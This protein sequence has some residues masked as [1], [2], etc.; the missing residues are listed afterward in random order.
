MAFR[1]GTKYPTLPLVLPTIYG[2]IEGMAP[3]APLE[4]SFPG[5]VSYTLEPADMHAG[6]LKARTEMHSDWVS[7]WI[8][9]LD[10]E[11]KR[12]Y[13]L[14]TLLHP[15][16]KTYH[17][18]EDFRLL[19]ESEKAWALRELRSEWATT[20]K[21]S[22]STQVHNEGAD[23]DSS[24]AP[25]DADV[26]E[27]LTKKRKVTLGSLLG[28]RAKKEKVLPGAAVAAGAR[29]E[30]EEYLADPEEVDLETPVLKWWQAKEVKWPSL[31]KMVKQYLAVP[32]SS[33]GV[34][35]VFSAAGK[36]HGDLSKSAK[37]ETLE[38]SLFAA[39]NT[40]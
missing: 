36:M 15:Y 30:L 5:E 24:G 31:A 32:A 14:A 26:A 20:W 33:A 28:G 9:N 16:F 27:P 7:R 40:D 13:A 25:A 22:G 3:D 10:P 38:H 29:D 11:A 12:T 6:V 35:R 17:F 19:P 34:E 37:D 18:V 39:F 23:H 1:Q 4:L 8:T 21:P 2:L